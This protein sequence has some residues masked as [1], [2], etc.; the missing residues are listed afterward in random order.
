[1]SSVPVETRW[2][3][4]RWGFLTF[5]V[6][7]AQIGLVFWLGENS[8][9]RPRR[10][11]N[12]P[13]LRFTGPGT[14][15]IVALSD[16]TLFALPHRQAFA[17]EAWLQTPPPPRLSMDWAEKP[18]W[19]ALP[20]EQLSQLLATF[21]GTNLSEAKL[22]LKSDTSLIMP[23]APPPAKPRQPSRLRVAGELARRQLLT[24]FE[25]ASWPHN[26]ILTNTVI[27][28]VVKAD[29]QILSADLVS[30]SGLVSADQQALKEASAATFNSVETSGPGRNENPLNELTWGTLIFEWRTL[31]LPMTNAPER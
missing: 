20:V 22:S 27:G 30:G 1:M 14:A 16:P 18:F 29:G 21:A 7:C 10:P 8:L 25:L 11:A 19:L 26:D 6:F 3:R 12:T 17:G 13:L 15:P 28:V 5:A 9:P 2:P 24:K 31:P 4:K 23:P